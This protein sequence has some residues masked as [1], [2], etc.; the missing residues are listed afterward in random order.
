MWPKWSFPQGVFNVY[1]R[2]DHNLNLKLAAKHL[3]VLA[4]I[5]LIVIAIAFHVLGFKIQDL[6]KPW[7]VSGDHIWVYTVV[8]NLQQSHSISTFN[9]LGWPF[10]GDMSN[11]GTI[12]VFEYL[13]FILGSLFFNSFTVVNFYAILGFILTTSTSFL[14]FHK[15]KF[16]LLSN[17]GLTLLLSLLPWHFQR[18]RWHVTYANYVA[19]PLFIIFLIILVQEDKTK[20]KVIKL[21]LILLLIATFVPYYWA[22]VEILLI[23]IFFILWINKKYELKTGL[24]SLWYLFIIPFVQLVQIIILKKQSLYEVMSSPVER[25]Y[26][27][28]EMYSGS[29]I[30]LL[31]PNPYSLIPFLAEIRQNFDEVSNLGKT[32][33]GPWNSLIGIFVILFCLVLFISLATS[34]FKPAIWIG[35]SENDKS[36][37]LLIQTLLLSFIVS[38]LFY[39]N[40]GLGSVLSFFITD[41]IRSWGRFYIFLI[42]FA[43][44]IAALVIKN[45]NIWKN[46]SLSTKQILISLV[47]VIALFDQGLKTLPNGLTNAVELQSEM[48]DFSN[49]M[50]KS[51]DTNCPVLQLPIMK[52]PE[53]GSIGAISDY[54]H[55]WLYLTDSQRKYSYGAVKGTQQANWQDRIETK[56]VKKIAGQAAAVGYCAVV[57]D[58]RGYESTVDTGN[59]WIRAAGKPIAVSKAT[60]LAAFKIDPKLT[61]KYAQESLVTLTWKGNA[62]AGV[63]QSGKQIDFYDNKF[64]LYALNPNKEAV[65]GLISFGVRGGKCTPSQSIEVKDTSTGEIVSTLKVDQFVKNVKFDLKLDSLE[66]KKFELTVTSKECTVEWYSDAKISIRNERFSLL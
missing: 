1:D 4:G 21:S 60:R 63:V 32:E 54:D 46:F 19:V 48:Q 10:V 33:S 36:Q 39:W 20:N 29:F 56:T 30:A 38:L 13:Y 22:F 28:I 43:F 16:S 37:T 14:M 49:Q 62:D 59:A 65:K 55:F 35:D 61:N 31:M 24:L 45:S 26:G 34:S 3:S 44:V 40:T 7:I 42:Y 47:L 27:F 58:F 17:S 64:Y 25:A 57:V 50:N 11:W 52:F 12:S 18:A 53:S 9:N 15:L 5:N 51:L 6:G 66:Q 8:Q 23:P 41:W 2:K